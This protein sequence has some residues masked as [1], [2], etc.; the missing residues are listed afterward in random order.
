M[1]RKFVL[2]IMSSADKSR[3]NIF[4]DNKKVE[5]RISDKT[6]ARESLLC[7]PEIIGT[8]STVLE[9][10]MITL[11]YL[12]HLFLNEYDTSS[13][14]IEEICTKRLIGHLTG[15]ASLR[16][17][18]NETSCPECSKRSKDL[19]TGVPSKKFR[20][21]CEDI[22]VHLNLCSGKTDEIKWG[23]SIVVKRTQIY[24]EQ[25]KILE[26]LISKGYKY[27]P[28]SY[29]C[30]YECIRILFSADPYDFKV[31]FLLGILGVDPIPKEIEDSLEILKPF[32]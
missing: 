4:F 2:L 19:K 30:E 31:K 18:K 6:I 26:Y 13:R 3:I 20:N 8:Y 12:S 7:R 27:K 29:S 10:D 28:S 17:K 5:I 22:E 11:K 32:V 9:K 21:P 16:C 25:R 14:L 1:L 24:K 23:R 15:Y